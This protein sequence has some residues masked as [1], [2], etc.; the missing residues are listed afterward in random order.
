MCFSLPLFALTLSLAVRGGEDA[1]DSDAPVVCY[2]VSPLGPRLPP[3]AG[4]PTGARATKRLEWIAAQGEREPASFLLVAS[5]PIEGLTLTLSPLQGEKGTIPVS[6]FDLRV[7]ARWV[8][9]GGAWYGAGSDGTDP[10][11]IPELLLH[12]PGLV[13][14]DAATRTSAPRDAK[15]LPTDAPALQPLSLAPGRTTQVWLT[16]ET[17]LDAAPGIYAGTLGLADGQDELASL[18]LLL[19]VL[20]FALPAPKTRHDLARDYT[21]AVAGLGDGFA[22]VEG[23]LASAVAAAGL[24]VAPVPV[25]PP[26]ALTENGGGGPTWVEGDDEVYARFGA[27]VDVFVRRGRPDSLMAQRWHAIGGTLLATGSPAVGLE[28]PAVWRRQVGLALHRQNYDG[29]LLPGLCEADGGWDDR[30]YLPR[31][32]RNLV[33]PGSDGVIPT[34]AWEGVREGLDDV[35]YATL[36]LQLADQAVASEVFTTASEGRKA[37]LWLALADVEQGDLDTLRL[38]MIAW[39]LKLRTVLAAPKGGE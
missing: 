27:R 2:A 4:L 14:T 15:G 35:R 7:V 18:E 19:R 25:V 29:F 39:I 20:P 32:A 9:A 8:Q 11:L 23:R 28:N 5:R 17:P 16:L 31:R 24:T 21:I 36:F 10:V 13:R 6:T 34:L 26:A 3:S 37:R 12:D 38:E 30:A 22:P 1:S 33:Y